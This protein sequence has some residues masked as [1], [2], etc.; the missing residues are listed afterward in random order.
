[1]GLFLSRVRPLSLTR[2]RWIWRPWF[3]ALGC[4]GG[5]TILYGIWTGLAL[6]TG[7]WLYIVCLVALGVTA[8]EELLEGLVR[9]GHRG[10]A[11]LWQTLHDALDLPWPRA[12]AYRS[13]HQL[14]PEY[15]Q[16][17]DVMTWQV[18][19]LGVPVNEGESQKEDSLTLSVYSALPRPAGNP[20]LNADLWHVVLTIEANWQKAGYIASSPLHVQYDQEMLCYDAN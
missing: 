14:F 2:F 18:Y 1:M 3:L 15:D 11:A 6:H 5:M 9:W 8:V 16:L 7:L 13:A 10:D 4:V 17:R 12:Q 19:R 20:N